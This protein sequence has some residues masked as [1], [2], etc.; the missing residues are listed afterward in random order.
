MCSGD[1]VLGC[2]PE[3]EWTGSPT[4]DWSGPP[5]PAA[6]SDVGPTRAMIQ[7]SPGDLI[8]VAT[9]GRYYYA[10]VLDRVRLFGGNWVFVFHRSSQNILDAADL[11][12]GPR[13]GYHAF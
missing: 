9:E 4:S 8:A 11:L 3:V 5:R 6:Q 13:T 1:L 2:S 7:I 10:L 12:D